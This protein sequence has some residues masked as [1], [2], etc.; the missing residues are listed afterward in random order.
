MRPLRIAS[1]FALAG[2]LLLNGAANADPTTDLV[3]DLATTVT[4]TATSA[5][6]CPQYIKSW[7]PI[8][9][10]PT[11]FIRNGSTWYREVGGAAANLNCAERVQVR[12]RVLDS[13]PYPFGPYKG[14]R[15][16]TPYTGKSPSGT[17]SVDVP[18]YGPD[19]PVIR[20]AGQ[21]TVHVEI[22]RYLSNG[23]LAPVQEG[24]MEYYYIIQPAASLTLTDPRPLGQGACAFDAAFLAL[25]AI[26]QG[27]PQVSGP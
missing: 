6:Y 25:D 22:W 26:D 12:A 23:R 3:D 18:Y 15:Y 19:A 5:P 16:D 20:P 13:A 4:D 2:T 27:S 9:N 1:A 17:G 8:W 10:Q 7:V 21:I 24:C 11:P 14:G